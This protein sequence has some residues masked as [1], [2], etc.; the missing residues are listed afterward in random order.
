MGCYYNPAYCLIKLEREKMTQEEEL[1]FYKR[2]AEIYK[3]QYEAMSTR[4][5]MLLTLAQKD[6]DQLMKE[7]EAGEIRDVKEEWIKKKTQINFYLDE[8]KE[9]MKVW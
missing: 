1:S 2:L 4:S 3:K 7:K 5:T 9:L 6:Y 8:V